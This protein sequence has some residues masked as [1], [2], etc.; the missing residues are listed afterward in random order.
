MGDEGNKQKEQTRRTISS[1]KDRGEQRRAKETKR[2]I[3]NKEKTIRGLLPKVFAEVGMK[4]MSTVNP[5]SQQRRR[6]GCDCPSGLG[7][8]QERGRRRLFSLRKISV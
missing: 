2:G 8:H 5:K 4:A 3:D 6:T 1:R 7:G